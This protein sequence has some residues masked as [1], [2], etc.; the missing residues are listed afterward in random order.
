M[1]VNVIIPVD[2]AGLI[3]VVL[4]FL[5]CSP[6]FPGRS[7]DEVSVVPPPTP[8]LSRPVL[9]YGVISVS[10]THVTAEPNQAGLSLGF[11]RR[12]SVVQVIER[13][14]INHGEFAE[15]WVFVEGSYR[16]WLRENVIRIY[17]NEAQA[18]TAAESLVQ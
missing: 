3:F 5:S 10:Y 13:R 1:R 18:K 12:G 8:P 17:D 6:N 16:G 11:F 14:S 4:F 7:T 2:Q 15:S 9:G